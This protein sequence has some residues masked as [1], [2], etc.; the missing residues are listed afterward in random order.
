MQLQAVHSGLCTPWWIVYY[1]HKLVALH[2]VHLP[3]IQSQSL[4]AVP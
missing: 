2:Q 1:S 4:C 3:G